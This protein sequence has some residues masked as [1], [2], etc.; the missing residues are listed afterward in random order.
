[1][2]A[3]SK[4]AL[5]LSSGCKTVPRAALGEQGRRAPR[6]S[7]RYFT[8]FHAITRELDFSGVANGLECWIWTGI[9]IATFYG[10]GMEQEQ[11]F[12]LSRAGIAN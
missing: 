4:F 1:M 9:D 2:A 5:L 11:L 7:S 6:Q 3:A 8:P 12:V 10:I